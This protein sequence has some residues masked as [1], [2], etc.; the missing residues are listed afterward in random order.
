MSCVLSISNQRRGTNLAPG[1]PLHDAKAGVKPGI[2]TSQAL[3]GAGCG[4]WRDLPG[5]KGLESHL[6][7]VRPWAVCVVHFLRQLPPLPLLIQV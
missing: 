3:R 4:W 5:T 6:G 7:M 1:V 2:I